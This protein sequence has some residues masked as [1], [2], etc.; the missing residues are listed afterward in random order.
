MTATADVIIHVADQNDNPPTFDR[1]P[2]SPVNTTY[3]VS[4]RAQRGYVITRLRTSDADSGVNSRVTFQIADITARDGDASASGLFQ[5]DRDLGIISVADGLSDRDGMTFDLIVMAM[6]GGKPPMSA[7]TTVSILV[8]SSVVDVPISGA[9]RRRSVVVRQN[10]LVVVALAVISGLITVCLVVAIVCIRRGDRRRRKP[11][12]GG[13]KSRK[14]NCRMESLQHAAPDTTHDEP[15][16]S[17]PMF[18]HNGVQKICE[19]EIT[20]YCAAEQETKMRLSSQVF[21]PN[22]RVCIIQLWYW[23]IGAFS[24]VYSISQHVLQRK[25][26]VL[27]LLHR[28]S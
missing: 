17:A 23:H 6:D 26:K 2:S 9:D 16:Q 21:R 3:L 24:N 12:A 11:P 19:P 13:A 28:K 22:Y 10:L 15:L 1:Y 8:N 5:V 25:P 4:T 7:F 14:Y 27:R 18:I 20:S